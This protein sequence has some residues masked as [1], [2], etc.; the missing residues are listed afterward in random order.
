MKEQRAITTVKRAIKPQTPVQ[1][2]RIGRRRV[3][4]RLGA[5]A[6]LLSLEVFKG[7][8]NQELAKLRAI[9]QYEPSAP[10]H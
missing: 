2:R 8:V 5:A 7:L 6:S 3:L 1:Q 9:A 4:S 10:P